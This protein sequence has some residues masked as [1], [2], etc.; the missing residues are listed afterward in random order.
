MIASDS[1]AKRESS[2][3]GRRFANERHIE[4]W[5]YGVLQRSAFSYIGVSKIFACQMSQHEYYAYK[6][7]NLKR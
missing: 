6:V 5:R 1:E 4:N 3:K 7:N 2:P